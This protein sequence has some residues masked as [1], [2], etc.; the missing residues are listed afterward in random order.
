MAQEAQEAQFRRSSASRS[1]WGRMSV[2]LEIRR[3][4]WQIDRLALAG[5]LSCLAVIEPSLT[6]LWLSSPTWADMADIYIIQ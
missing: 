2:L 4:P 5:D 3:R 1:A 6:A